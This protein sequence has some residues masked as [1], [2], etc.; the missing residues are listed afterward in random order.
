[1]DGD[2]DRVLVARELEETAGAHVTTSRLSLG[3]TTQATGSAALAGLPGRSEAITARTGT[4]RPTDREGRTR[5]PAAREIKS[6]T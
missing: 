4:A 1:M 2:Q 5:R 3:A 6:C